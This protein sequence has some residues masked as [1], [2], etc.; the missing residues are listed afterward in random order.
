MEC[1]ILTLYK[2]EFFK[3]FLILFLV[4]SGMPVFVKDGV[5]VGDFFCEEYIVIL[6]NEYSLNVYSEILAE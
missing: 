4:R 3:Y 6:L 5:L 2:Y 1:K